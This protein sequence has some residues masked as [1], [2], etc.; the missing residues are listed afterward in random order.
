PT[1]A[2][3]PPRKPTRHRRLCAPRFKVRSTCGVRSL[4]QLASTRTDAAGGTA[5]PLIRQPRQVVRS[6]D[7]WPDYLHRC[8]PCGNPRYWEL[9]YMLTR[10]YRDIIG[11]ALLIIGGIAFSWYAAH[12]YDLGSLRRMGPGMFPM[13]LGLVLAVFGLMMMVPAFFR[14]GTMP[15]IRIWSPLFVL[16]S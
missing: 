15:E 13:A 12:Q 7:G 1:W 10:D 3:P 2:R 5:G 11:G 9:S 8:P 16:S 14:A 6:P 4:R